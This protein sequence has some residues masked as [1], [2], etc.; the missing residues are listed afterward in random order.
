MLKLDSGT[1]EQLLYR[2]QQHQ[3]TA[4]EHS[5]SEV[6]VRISNY[7]LLEDFK[8]EKNKKYSNARLQRILMSKA[9]YSVDE[10]IASHWET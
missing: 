3:T 1:T 10:F 7:W 4:F 2:I 5:T 9:L 6:G 8:S